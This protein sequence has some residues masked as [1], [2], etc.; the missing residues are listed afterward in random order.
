MSRDPGERGKGGRAGRRAPR[1]RVQ[2]AGGHAVHQL[3]QV[4]VPHGPRRVAHLQLVPGGTGR[5]RALRRSPWGNW[6]LAAAP[7]IR[8][9]YGAS[10]RK[11]ECILLD[12]LLEPTVPFHASTRAP[13]PRSRFGC[14]VTCERR[15]RCSPRKPPGRTLFGADPV[16]AHPR[17][18]GPNMRPGAGRGRCPQVTA[19]SG[20]PVS[21]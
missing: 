10:S 1:S 7:S 16:Q 18:T 13:L 9:F 12:L 15:P 8:P 5:L 2:Q 14:P 20:K 3:H 6:D 21:K 19:R 17:P 4:P 11:T